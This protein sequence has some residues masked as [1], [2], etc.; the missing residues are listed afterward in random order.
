[1]KRLVD[2]KVLPREIPFNDYADT[3][4]VGVCA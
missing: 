4:F 2:Y 1:M 3:S